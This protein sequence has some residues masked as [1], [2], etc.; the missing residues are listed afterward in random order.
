MFSILSD[1]VAM[2]KDSHTSISDGKRFTH[3]RKHPFQEDTGPN[4]PILFDDHYM[5]GG[6]R[7]YMAGPNSPLTEPRNPPAMARSSTA[8][9]RPTIQRTFQP[10]KATSDISPSSA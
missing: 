8:A 7:A 4:G 3:I 1:M 10:R 9:S 2:L 5:I 6:L